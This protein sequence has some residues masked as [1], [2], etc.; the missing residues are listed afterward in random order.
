MSNT[1]TFRTP[2]DPQQKPTSEKA[3]TFCQL[4]TLM[5]KTLVTLILLASPILINAADTYD[6][7]STEL[8]EAPIYITGVEGDVSCQKQNSSDDE[9]VTGRK[10]ITQG[11]KIVTGKNGKA[12]LLFTNGTSIALGGDSVLFINEFRQAG[13]F[14]LDTSSMNDAV[15]S[16][17]NSETTGRDPMQDETGVL[18]GS[19]KREPSW[20]QTKLFLAKGTMYARVKKL[21]KKSYFFSSSLLGTAKV[22]GTAWRQTVTVNPGKFQIVVKI[23]MQEGRVDFDP[24][25]TG[26]ENSGDIQVQQQQQQTFTGTFASAR[27]FQLA[28]N[29]FQMSSVDTELT[30]DFQLNSFAGGITDQTFN[31]FMSNFLPEGEYDNMALIGNFSNDNTNPFYSGDQGNQN[32]GTAGGG[33][34]SGGGGGGGSGGGGGG[35]NSSSGGGG[36]SNTG[37]SG[38][39]STPLPTQNAP[40]S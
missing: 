8:Q 21:Q 3:N 12:K 34:G 28:L 24:V 39:T 40:S 2:P 5:K 6:P 37:G 4:S 17:D 27:D 23:E 16:D 33:G 14:E 30:F 38:V 18:L 36:S 26:N 9:K 20:S 25:K 19:M 13:A 1:S 29:L 22:V 10:K 15:K 11:T 31:A 7:N 35:G 32:V